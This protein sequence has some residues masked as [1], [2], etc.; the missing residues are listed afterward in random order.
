MYITMELAAFMGSQLFRCT[1]RVWEGAVNTDNT[2]P[3]TLAKSLSTSIPVHPLS[4][5]VGDGK[6]LAWPFGSLKQGTIYVTDHEHDI[7]HCKAIQNRTRDR[8]IL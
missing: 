3:F 1:I 4:W 5:T 7:Q 6:S 8:R 2:Y